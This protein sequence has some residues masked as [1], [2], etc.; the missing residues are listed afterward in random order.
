MNDAPV[1]DLLRQA[2]IKTDNRLMYFSNSGCQDFRYIGSRST[3]T[4]II[5]YQGGPIEHGTHV[6][7]PVAQSSA[8]NDYNE[9][10]TEGMDLAHFRML[11]H[12]SLN[13]ETRY[14]SRGI[15]FDCIGW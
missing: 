6:T 5:L 3:R 7:G 13:K 12:E 10:C 4:Y 2:N 14:S 8:E 15:S 9:A 1:N 11:M